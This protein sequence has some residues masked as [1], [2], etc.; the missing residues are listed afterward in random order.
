MPITSKNP[1][2]FVTKTVHPYMDHPVADALLVALSL[3][4][5]EALQVR[6]AT[7]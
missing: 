4:K 6:T 1:R 2:L 5:P 7:A 3:Q